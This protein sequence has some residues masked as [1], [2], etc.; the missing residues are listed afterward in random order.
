MPR[1]L[2]AS[3]AALALTASLA[4]CATPPTVYAPAASNT[5]AGYRETRIESDRYRVVFRANPDLGRA[6]VED[7]A[8]RRAAEL[9]RQNGADWFRVVTRTTEQVGGTSGGGTSVGVGGSSGSRGSHV[10]VGIGINLTPDSRKYQTTLEVLLGHGPKPADENVYD[11]GA[12]LNGAV[13][14]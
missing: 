3:L 12:I 11:A 5:S 7:L 8:L 1:Q 13:S 9:A 4:A 14:G 6:E 2:L 10:G